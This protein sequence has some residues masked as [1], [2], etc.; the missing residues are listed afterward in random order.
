MSENYFNT[1]D[2]LSDFVEYLQSFN[3]APKIE[4]NR[5]Q[6]TASYYIRVYKPKRKTISTLI[7]LSD[8]FSNNFGLSDL[9]TFDINIEFDTQEKIKGVVNK[10]ANAYN[11][12]RCNNAL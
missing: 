3:P 9:D 5:A 12:K 2:A 11:L 8:H 6:Y 10:I 4:V 1:Y 7:R